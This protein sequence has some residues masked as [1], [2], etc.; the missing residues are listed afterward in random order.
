MVGVDMVLEHI[1]VDYKPEEDYKVI[2]YMKEVD[3]LEDYMEQDYKPEE[4]KV[5]FEY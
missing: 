1:L 3:K 5:D 4:H 2:D